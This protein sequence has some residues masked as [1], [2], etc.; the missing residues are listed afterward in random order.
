[1]KTALPPPL[2]L[3][4]DAGG[5]AMSR[6]LSASSTASQSSNNSV[7]LTPLGQTITTPTKYV[8]QRFGSCSSMATSEDDDRINSNNPLESFFDWSVQ[9]DELLMSTY[10]SHVDN[11]TIAPFAGKLPPSGIIQRVAKD[12]NKRAKHL[13][14]NFPHSLNA[15]RKRLLLLCGRQHSDSNFYND[16]I[17]DNEYCGSN[18]P[19][20]RSQFLQQSQDNNYSQELQKQQQQQC[21]P[22]TPLSIGPPIGSSSLGGG[23][24]NDF[25]FFE[26]PQL[27]GGAGSQHRSESPLGRLSGK[28][29]YAREGDRE[30][31]VENH[32]NHVN[33]VKNWLLNTPTAAS[34][35]SS[36]SND[37]YPCYPTPAS[38]MMVRQ[39]SKPFVNPLASPFREKV[40]DLSHSMN[41][42]PPPPISIGFTSESPK[43]E[44]SLEESSTVNYTSERKRDSLK[45]K[46]GM[47]QR[48]S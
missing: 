35:S 4:I 26:P 19:I 36:I 24:G 14:R 7:P 38:P 2:Q 3:N 48:R 1:M 17:S 29:G 40:Q 20:K 32:V 9:D 45:A 41:Y 10:Q 34:A 11:P 22:T 21:Q 6:T 27:F 30:E 25:D 15:T 33:N 44:V 12:T 13:G 47:K 39:D 37:I 28:L 18:S 5:I 8:L 42:P 46:R 43:S 31:V 16:S 23:D